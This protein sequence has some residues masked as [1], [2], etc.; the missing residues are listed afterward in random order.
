VGQFQ[1]ESFSLKL[2]D[3]SE[4]SKV[5]DIEEIVREGIRA[6]TCPYFSLRDALPNADL[7]IMPY[8]SLLNQETRR[9]IGV[10]IENTVVVFD[11]AHNVFEAV[12]QMHE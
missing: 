9:Q 11:E 7:V 6:V 2:C 4:S 1:V 3:Q 8:Q 12:N 10:D 5:M